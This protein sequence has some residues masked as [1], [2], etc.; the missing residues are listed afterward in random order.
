MGISD[1]RKVWVAIVTDHGRDG[2]G[3][4]LELLHVEVGLLGRGHQH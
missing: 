4:L 2:S 3:A 1:H